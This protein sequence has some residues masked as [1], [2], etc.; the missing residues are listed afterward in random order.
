MATGRPPASP[1]CSQEIMNT[2]VPSGYGGRGGGP[3]GDRPLSGRGSDEVTE[4]RLDRRAAVAEL[5]DEL[6]TLADLL[7]RTEVGTDVLR[8]STRQLREIAPALR[9]RL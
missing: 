7:A 2:A 6:R 1:A 4:D 5:A 3:V 9:E 8:D